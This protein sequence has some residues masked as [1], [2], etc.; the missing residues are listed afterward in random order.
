MVSR[1]YKRQSIKSV[2]WDALVSKAMDS[3]EAI[4]GADV[5]KDAIVVSVRWKDR[6]HERPWSV[7][8]SSE[9]RRLIDV[10]LLMKQVCSVR[11]AMESTG[12][13]GDAL[14]HAATKAGIDVVRVSGKVVSDYREVYD[15]VPSQH[16]GKDAA[17]IAELAGH[18]KVKP[19]PYAERTEL[20]QKV[21]LELKRIEAWKKEAAQWRG[22]LEA[23][24]AR[25][26]P[27]L[28]KL[29]DLT[30]A[31]PMKLLQKYASPAAVAANAK[32]ARSDMS[33]WSRK[34]LEPTVIDKVIE[35]AETTMGV[36]MTEEDQV[37]LQ[38]VVSEICEREKKIS[39]AERRLRELVK[40]DKQVERLKAIGVTTICLIITRVGDPRNF[41]SSGA[42]LKAMGLNL[43]EMS[44]GRHQG[45]LAITKRG[46][47]VARQ[48]LYLVAWRAVQQPAVKQWYNAKIQ[49]DQSCR[50]AKA[51]VGVMRKL[52]RAIWHVAHHE[53]EFDWSKVFPGAPLVS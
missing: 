44:S 2:V 11:L 34:R 46:S 31:T 32:E 24:L 30:L 21:G 25:H 33:Q 50:K 26:W 36:P 49:R 52:A 16:D 12:T 37:W 17:M 40:N 7:K 47:S 6:S 23:R 20:E 45:R 8:N 9:I 22:R 42:F 18:G 39:A 51:L 27:E 38:E 35:S 15:G 53:E 29:F 13:Y 10:L 1:R 14:R 43:K 41:G 48:Y 5:G 3:G 28:D 19:W 4:V